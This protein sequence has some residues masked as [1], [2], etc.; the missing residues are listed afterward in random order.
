M[1]DPSKRLGAD[2]LNKLKAHPFFEG[3]NFEGL[4]AMQPPLLEKYRKLSLQQQKE[5]KFL[6]RNKKPSSQLHLNTSKPALNF[7]DRVRST[8]S[9]SIITESPM[10]SSSYSHSPDIR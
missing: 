7:A 6:P 2:D 3:V 4:Y 10:S 8:I 9:A 1:K 5:I